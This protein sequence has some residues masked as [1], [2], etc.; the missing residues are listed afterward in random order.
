MKNLKNAKLKKVVVDVKINGRKCS[1]YTVHTDDDNSSIKPSA[2]A[3]CI[4]NPKCCSDKFTRDLALHIKKNLSF[5]IANDLLWQKGKIKKILSDAYALAP[6]AV[7]EE[8]IISMQTQLLP[9]IPKIHSPLTHLLSKSELEHFKPFQT[10]EQCLSVLF[11]AT[12]LDCD[13]LNF[14]ASVER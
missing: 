13:I 6:S 10:Y 9:L 3:A 14:T 12:F 8:E 4:N 2:L 11:G 5:K 7:V 1:Q